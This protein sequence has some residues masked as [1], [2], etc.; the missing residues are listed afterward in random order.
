MPSCPTPG[1]ILW[2]RIPLVFRG[3]SYLSMRL[4]GT[5]LHCHYFILRCRSG[6]LS[7]RLARVPL[8]LLSHS[9]CQ[10]RHL[11]SGC[12]SSCMYSTVHTYRPMLLPSRATLYLSMAP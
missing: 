9:P 1:G 8:V 4:A 6:R 10:P 3:K 2:H 11:L 7:A 12:S 5:F